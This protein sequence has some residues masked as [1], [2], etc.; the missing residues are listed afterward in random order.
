MSKLWP[1]VLEF[2]TLV[3]SLGQFEQ[4]TGEQEAKNP[5]HE[6]RGNKSKAVDIFRL[7]KLSNFLGEKR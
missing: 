6:K 7:F 1:D 2:V 3:L 4:V 5:F